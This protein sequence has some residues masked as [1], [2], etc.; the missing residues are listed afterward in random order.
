[1]SEQIQVSTVT[2][3]LSTETRDYD[4]GKLV[5]V[6]RTGGNKIH[7]RVEELRETYRRELAQ[8]GDQRRAK[9]TA[10]ELKKQLP[11][12]LWCGRFSERKND[13]L[14]KHSGLLCADLD[15]LNGE[16]ANVREKLLDSPH[17]WTLFKSPGGDG[18]KAVFRVP[19]DQARHTGSF[20][21]VE[22]HVKKL[23]GVQIDQACRDVARL[24]FL[25]YDPELIYK[26]EAREIEP[27]PEKPRPINNGAVDLSERQRIAT[28]LLGAVDW[29][30]E[31]SG[32]VVCPGKHLH[33][34]ADNDRDC[35]IE[36]DNIPT[37]HCFHNSCRGILEG[38][39]HALRSR[40]GKAEYISASTE[41]P[42]LR[43]ETPNCVDVDAVELPPAPAPYVPPPLTL[44]PVK[45]E[46]YV[47]AAGEALNVDASFILLPLLSAL[48]SAIGNAR[49]ILLK[50]GFIQ[51]PVIWTGIVGRSG[52]R[53]SPALEAGC[54]AAM[55]H[56]RELVL[57]NKAEAAAYDE[58]LAKWEAANRKERG[59]KPEPKPALTSL[60]DDLT[61][62]TL[63]D[64]IQRNPRG[65]LVRKDELSHWFASF[66]QY[67]N[68]KGADVSRWLSLHTGAFFGLDRRTD[69]RSY[70]IFQPRVSITGGIQPKVLAR[71]LTDDFFERGLPARFL[72][73]APPMRQ[74]KW[75]EAVIPD[76]LR[77]SA[78]ALF[79]ELRL[80]Q[81]E[82][83]DND[84]PRASLLRLDADAKAAFVKYYNEC[85][86][87]AVE[88]DENEEAAWNKLSGYA[89]RLALI[90]QL[91]S[92]PNART[93]TGEVMAAACDLA[94]WFG[95]E[96]VRIYASMA[97]TREQREQRKLIEFVESRGDTASVREI[98]QG[99]WPL[100][101]QREK[102][103]QQLAALERTGM[104]KWEPV[105]T[106][107]KGGRPTR[108]FQLLTRIYSTKPAP[109][110]GEP[111]SSVDV[112]VPKTVQNTCPDELQR[113][114]E[115]YGMWDDKCPCEYCKQERLINDARG[116]FNATAAA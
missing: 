102:T 23:T 43:G 115:C 10:G 93:V 114:P 19:A 27:L 61:L 25:S 44:L 15:S 28:E 68:A 9:Q 40:I 29:E 55:E 82:L 81:P 39:N 53:K 42:G 13:A 74:D 18:L 66:D 56:E 1:M 69:E 57:Q 108:K 51:P 90:G 14:V 83:G 35:M 60:M 70:R 30:S 78:L 49:S 109:L 105:G 62:A 75:S 91:A 7:R 2:S 6:I 98:M 116:L 31:T 65:V 85:G 87:S 112:E 8:H 73:A 26:A 58:A 110:R 20:R 16:L 4:A 52:A 64:A 5:E 80:L 48:G 94:R 104:G 38:V 21:A 17:L 100:K 33:T 107:A 67:T 46:D 111:A 41:F 86:A 113:P 37:V 71:A 96:A 92:N 63:A 88:C 72:F 59:V 47:Q 99:Y 11:A 106:T 32:F 22:Q 3:A 45:L 95:S 76:D 97:E 84:Q 24:C 89:A 36:L 50:R 101:N 79:Q 12:V 77:E 54:F 103:E 34:S